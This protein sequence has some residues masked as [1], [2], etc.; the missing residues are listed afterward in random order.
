MK[1][2]AENTYVYLKGVVGIDEIPSAMEDF[3]TLFKRIFFNSICED[4]IKTELKESCETEIK[5][6]G[7]ET[8]V[9]YLI[10]S[11]RKIL[12]AFKEVDT[13]KKVGAVKA[14]LNSKDLT[15]LGKSTQ[16]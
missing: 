1:Q 12:N 7:L 2:D 16:N 13:T 4:F 9:I 8:V 15:E 6:K 3:D 14:M 10:E 5:N 11:W